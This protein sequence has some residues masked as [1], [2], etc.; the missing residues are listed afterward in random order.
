MNYFTPDLILRGQSQDPQVVDD[1]ERLW[2]NACERYRAHLDSIRS[3]MP[4]GLRHIED[5]YYLHDAKIHGMGKKDRSFLIVLQLDTPPHSLLTLTY[6]LLRDPVVKQTALPLEYSSLPGS[7]A[8]EYDELDQDGKDPAA[9]H[10]VI[11][12]SNGWEVC[13]TFSNVAVQEVQS[14]FPVQV[15]VVAR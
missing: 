12:L 2:D 5:H 15:E 13:L 1:V 14:L 3:K 7:T 8:W 11:L 10:Q 6:D 9:W 4:S